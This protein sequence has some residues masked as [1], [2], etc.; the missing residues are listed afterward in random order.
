LPITVRPEFKLTPPAW[1]EVTAVG[2]ATS[3]PR[4]LSQYREGNFILATVDFQDEYKQKRNLVADWRNDGP[5]PLGMQLGFCIDE[6]NETAPGGFPGEKIHFYCKQAKSAA[7]VA[8]VAS[9]D[10]PG[11]PSTQCLV[12]D[13][14]AAVTIPRD[15]GP[16]TIADG[17][18]TTYLY[19]VS[20][21]PA[22]YE[23]ATDART[24]KVTRSWASA[25]AVGDL[26][27]LA[28]LVVFRPSDQPAP[29]VSELSLQSADGVGSASAIVDGTKLSVS[30]K[31]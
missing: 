11:H 19:P 28:Y 25:D 27:A 18:I 31:N 10:I 1:R 6:S 20:T 14:A 9:T 30:F 13:H 21:G 16:I 15:A 3:P 5:A 12:F 23:S 4:H 8:L 24:V 17:S 26:R 2:P 29:A 7:L 22:A